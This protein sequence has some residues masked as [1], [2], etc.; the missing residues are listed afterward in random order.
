MNLGDIRSRGGG[1]TFDKAAEQF[2]K[3]FIA[4]TAG[5]RSPV[6]MQGHQD[7]LRVH[8]HPFF[9]KKELTEITPGRSESASANMVKPKPT[10]LLFDR[11]HREL[12]KTVLEEEKLK[13]DRD[14]NR[15]TAYSLRHQCQKV[16]SREGHQTDT[17][18]KIAPPCPRLTCRSLRVKKPVRGRGETGRRTGLRRLSARGEIRDVELLKFGE[19]CQ[20]AIP[21]QALGRE[22]GRWEGVE[23]RRAAPKARRR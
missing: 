11:S 3:E 10:D 22:G 1:V 20:M 5:E 14:G 8:L 9:G 16:E 15:R 23:T 2:L 4:L 7:R 6:Y 18:G 12:L 13:F 17:K 19:P 21:S